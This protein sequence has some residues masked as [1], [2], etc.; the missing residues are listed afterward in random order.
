MVRKQLPPLIEG[1]ITDLN[2]PNVNIYIREN[3][4]RELANV[5][6]RIVDALAKFNVERNRVVNASIERRKRRS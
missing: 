2:N 5:S 3:N 6:E 4:A 1:W